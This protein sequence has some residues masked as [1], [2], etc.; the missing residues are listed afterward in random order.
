[1][2]WRRGT[3]NQQ[4]GA[5]RKGHVKEF[6]VP[7]SKKLASAEEQGSLQVVD[8]SMLGEHALR[9][10][11]AYARS[12]DLPAIFRKAIESQGCVHVHFHEHPAHVQRLV[13]DEAVPAGCIALSDVQ[14]LNNRVCVHD[15]PVFTLYKGRHEALDAREAAIGATD[16]IVKPDS[17][18]SAVVFE[19]RRRDCGSDVSMDAVRLASLLAKHCFGCVVSVPEVHVLR[20]DGVILVARVL[21]VRAD[22]ED[23][24]EDEDDY[25]GLLAASTTTYVLSDG[26][27]PP[28][29]RCHVLNVVKVP[30]RGERV[31]CVDVIC[32]D[33]EVFPVKRALLR[34]SLALTKAAQAGRGKY[35]SAEVIRVPLDCCT[36]DRVLLYLEH[37]KRGAPFRFDPTLAP[38]L[39]AAALAL[40]I[41]G[42]EDACR[43]V[44]GSFDERVRKAPIRLKEVQQRNARGSLTSPRGETWLLLDGMIL[45]ISRWLPEHPGGDSIIPEQALNCD[46]TVMFE[47]FHVSRQSFLYLREFYVGELHPNDYADVPLPN[48]VPPGGQNGASPAFLAELRRHTRWRLKQEDLQFPVWKSF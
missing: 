4:A 44:L 24:E 13:I 33:D 27:A 12:D 23:E 35:E 25:R 45:D 34:P 29:T 16:V 31:D 20:V 11:C 47:L 43:R 36:F 41:Q 8:A 10:A 48:E 39:L 17:D 7:S 32:A 1:M 30:S 21:E 19:V 46:A 14:R 15:A 6:L 28:G 5:I 38:E 18:L 9:Q 22:R 3:Q 26:A 40:K 37:E 2:A 42:L